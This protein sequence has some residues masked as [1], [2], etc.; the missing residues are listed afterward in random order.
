MCGAASGRASDRMRMDSL[1]KEVGE[2]A[3]ISIGVAFPVLA[4]KAYNNS[5]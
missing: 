4:A 1:D 2:M 5:L 3:G